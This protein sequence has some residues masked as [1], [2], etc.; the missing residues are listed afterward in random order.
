MIYVVMT[1]EEFM[2]E[3]KFGLRKLNTVFAKYFIVNIK[4]LHGT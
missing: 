2:Q 3:N 1:K 4:Y